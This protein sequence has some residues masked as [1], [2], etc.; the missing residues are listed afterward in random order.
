MT[1]DAQIKTYAELSPTEQTDLIFAR[2]SGATIELYVPALD[3]WHWT[4]KPMFL[5]DMAYRVAN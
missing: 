5:P 4:R 2:E 1:M 3:E